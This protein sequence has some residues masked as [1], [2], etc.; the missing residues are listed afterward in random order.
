MSLH[1]ADVR[2]SWRRSAL[3]MALVTTLAMTLAL[4][5][6]ATPTAPFTG[7]NA[8]A[9]SVTVPADIRRGAESATLVIVS[10]RIEGKGPYSFALDTGA[11]LTLIDSSLARE[12]RLPVAGP[13]VDIAGVGGKQFVTPVR[14]KVW[15]IGAQALPNHVISSTPLTTLRESDGID[16][17]L[18]SDVL[19][20]FSSV[21]I[22]FANSEV[23]LTS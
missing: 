3:V 1:A 17:L 20:T 13:L 22:D 11:S 12:L 16:G 19:S 6:C 23:I 7:V 21:T 2:G 5:G 18:G 4:T 9:K 8:N 15:S 10:L 14:V